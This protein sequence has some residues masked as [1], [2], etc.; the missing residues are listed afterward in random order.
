MKEHK[1]IKMRG[2]IAQWKLFFENTILSYSLSKAGGMFKTNSRKYSL[3]TFIR[4]G[5]RIIKFFFI[6][7][8]SSFGFLLFKNIYL[9][10]VEFT[11]TTRCSL[12][13]KNCITYIPTIEEKHQSYMNFDEYKLYL[14]NLLANIK[15]L[16]FFVLIGGEPL[17][18][19]DLNKFLQYALSQKKI[20]C[21]YMITNG[22]MDI[23]DEI[24]DTL[25][26]NRKR[27][28]VVISNYKSNPD[29][30]PRL[31]TNEIINKLNKNNVHVYYRPIMTWFPV[32]D[33]KYRNRS[34]EE[35][36]KYYLKCKMFCPSVTAGKLSM[37]SRA[38]T[39]LL[40][41]LYIPSESSDGK[42]YLD[43]SKPADKNKIISF[44]SNRSFGVCNYCGVVEDSMKE[45]IIPA[46][47]L[48]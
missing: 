25:K 24:M 17:L 21:V 7:I 15:K 1:D 8:R 12:K 4:F 16:Q 27:A 42:E 40:R 39:I 6:L 30:L 38:S 36:I 33:I 44:Y 11:I 10:Y 14:D 22:T 19:K 31:K 45:E 3:A 13:C 43:L 28:F 46:V 35:N 41:K 26:K 2:G 34:Y 18:H 5:T 20:N 23:S 32:S 37:C 47:Q 29:L 9:S 48:D